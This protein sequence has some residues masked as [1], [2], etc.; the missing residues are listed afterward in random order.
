M[1]DFTLQVD[2]HKYLP[3]GGREVHAILTVTGTV[4]QAPP[5]EAAEVIIIDTSG[6]MTGGKIREARQA[7]KAAVDA[8][9]EG[10]EFAVIAGDTSA[11]MV[12]PR[13]RKLAKVGQSTRD[14][15]KKAID[16]LDANGGTSI[17]QW[18]LLAC[19]LLE[20]RPGAI[21]HAL[22]MTDGQNNEG[23]DAFAR[24]LKKCEGRFVCDSLG[25]GDDWVPDELRKVSNALL[26]AFDFVRDQKDLAEFFTRITEASMGKTVAELALRVWI[27]KDATL[28]YIRQVSPT[29]LDLSGKRT[30]FNPLTGDYPTG[31]WGAEEREYHLCVEVPTAAPGQ[32]IRAAWV[33][34]VRP[35]TGDVHASGNV[36]AHWTEDLALSTRINRKVAHY[37]GQ[38]ELHELIQEGLSARAAGDTATATARL[39]K[40]KQ[41]ADSSGREDTARLLEKVVEIDPGTGTA[42]LRRNVEKAD[43]IELDTGSTRTSQL[44]QES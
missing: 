5:T 14:N 43:E 10:V 1:S 38:A 3:L 4:A 42:R 26:G 21:R 17:G 18:L 27:P 9:R 29:L 25:V 32:E 8:L 6:S 31:S 16:S 41:L 30:P 22:L 36:L 39:A 15:A 11:R 24:A 33:K 2:Q 7:A 34:L 23:E 37:T 44:R 20:S 40:A 28:K 35:D 12:Y 13:G 19:D